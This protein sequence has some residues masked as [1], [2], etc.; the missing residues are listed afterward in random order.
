MITHFIIGSARDKHSLIRLKPLMAALSGH[1]SVAGELVR[2][3]PITPEI[4]RR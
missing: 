1:L 2:I 3:E 4:T